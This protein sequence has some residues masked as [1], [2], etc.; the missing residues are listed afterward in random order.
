MSP[1]VTSP[2]ATASQKSALAQAKYGP[3]YSVVTQTKTAVDAGD[4]KKAGQEFG[5]FEENWA[6]VENSVKAQSSDTYNSIETAMD[7]VKSGIKQ[8][9]KTKATNGLQSLNNSIDKA[10]KS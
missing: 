9:D 8:S 10:A 7:Q 6:K 1:Q 4:F 3:L 2:Q 5:K